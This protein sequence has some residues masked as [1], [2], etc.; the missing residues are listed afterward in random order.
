[1]KKRGPDAQRLAGFCLLHSAFCLLPSA[2]PH[3]IQTAL[4]L[5]VHARCALLPLESARAHW[6]VDAES[7]KG[8]T[9]DG[10]IA[11]AFDVA[12]AGARRQEL[13][14]WKECLGEHAAAVAAWPVGRVVAEIIGTQRETLRGAE[15]EQLFIVSRPHVKRLQEAGEITGWLAGHTRLVTVG[16]LGAFLERRRVK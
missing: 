11:W 10:R 13:R 5:T 16:S 6:G 2:F 1:M 9:E 14:I 7:V 15:V 8:M 12:L 3:M 4:P